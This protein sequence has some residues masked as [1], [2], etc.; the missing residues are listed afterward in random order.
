MDRQVL[1]TGANSG[2]GYLTTIALSRRG[3]SVFAAM[4]DAAGRNRPAAERL[5][6]IGEG[7]SA[8]INWR[9][10]G[11]VELSLTG[12]RARGRPRSMKPIM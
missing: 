1:V 3:H 10:P 7:A 11:R 12:S 8:A 2:F 4:R 6:R 9:V 5:Q